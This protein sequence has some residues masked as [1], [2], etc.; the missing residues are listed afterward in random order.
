MTQIGALKQLVAVGR[1][2][3]AADGGGLTPQETLDAFAVR[4][5]PLLARQYR[6]FHTLAAGLAIARWAELT[7]EEGAQLRGR[8]VDAIL[9]FVSP[10]AVTRAPGHPL[11][12][13]RDRPFA[14]PVALRDRPR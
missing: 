3:A 10:P 9:P 12:S 14:L 1:N 5:R 2:V 4:L 11:P 7:D 6:M 13:A 8:C